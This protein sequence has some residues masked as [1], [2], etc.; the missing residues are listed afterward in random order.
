MTENEFDNELDLLMPGNI[1]LE[2]FLDI[3]TAKKLSQVLG[4]FLQ[5]FEETSVSNALEKI[6]FALSN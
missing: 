2:C 6:N 5:A 4:I 3:E 1:P